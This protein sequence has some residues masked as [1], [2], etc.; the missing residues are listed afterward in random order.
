MIITNNTPLTQQYNNI[1]KFKAITLFSENEFQYKNFKA[2]LGVSVLGISKILDSSTATSDD[3]LYSLQLNTN[4]SYQVPKWHSTFALYYK[5]VGR[6]HQFVEVTNLEGNQGFVKG[7]TDAY[8]W[9]DAT[10]TKSFFKDLFKATVGIRNLL[11]V[12]TV[13]TTAFAAGAHNAAPTGLLFSYGRSYFIKL[14]YNL[15]L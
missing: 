8:G 4:V 14:A 9:L 2:R 5:Y 10:A 7:T 6:Q 11:D 15:N 12:S 13:N 1:D 3:F